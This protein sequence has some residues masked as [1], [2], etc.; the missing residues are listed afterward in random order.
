VAVAKDDD[1]GGGID[2]R[3][4]VLSALRTCGTGAG[5]GGE[6]ADAAGSDRLVGAWLCR[7]GGE[8]T[9]VLFCGRG[10]IACVGAKLP[11]LKS[12]STDQ[13]IEALG[14]VGLGAGWL[15]ASWTAVARNSDARVMPMTLRAANARFLK[16]TP[17]RI[18]IR[19]DRHNDS[20]FVAI[21]PLRISGRAHLARWSCRFLGAILDG[22]AQ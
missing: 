10:G 1:A 5:G 4:R 15:R 3:A 16:F 6:G 12:S 22:G 18:T 8:V 19:R 17:R 20:R 7:G 13:S 9:R 2:G 21:A 11:R 14:K